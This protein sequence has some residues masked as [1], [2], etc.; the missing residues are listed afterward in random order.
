MYVHPIQETKLGRK[1]K[2]L[3]LCVCVLCKELVIVLHYIL[4]NIN[5]VYILVYGNVEGERNKWKW[6]D[7]IGCPKK[8]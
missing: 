7:K 5:C 4:I 8:G 3:C 2:W 6:L 1:S